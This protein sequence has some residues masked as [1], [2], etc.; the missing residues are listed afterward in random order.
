MRQFWI[1]ALLSALVAPMSAVQA[2]CKHEPSHWRFGK[3]VSVLWS[4]DEEAVCTSR[5]IYPEKIEKIE[6][7]SKPRHGSAG[8]A[9]TES[10]AYK[11]NWGYRGSDTFTYIIFS[12]DNAKNGADQI[13]RVNV[14]VEVR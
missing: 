11:P 14:F 3:T 1:V 12:S 7:A 6:I 10:V 2:K 4:T 8:V 13:A 5:N 9:G